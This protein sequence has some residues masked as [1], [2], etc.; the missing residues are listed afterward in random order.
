[1]M[2]KKF[3]SY[4]IFFVSNRNFTTEHVKNVQNLRC[5]KVFCSKF[6]VFLDLLYLNCQILGFFMFFPG[7]QVKWQPWLN[8]QKCLIQTYKIKSFFKLN[9]NLFVSKNNCLNRI[10]KCKNL[11]NN[12]KHF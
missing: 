12:K 7:F 9:I 11:Q 8:V 4:D 1:M 6:Q 2:T 3:Y 10:I 5:F